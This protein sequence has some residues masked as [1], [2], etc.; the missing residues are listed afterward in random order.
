MT[1]LQFVS[2][3]LVAVSHRAGDYSLAAVPWHASRWTGVAADRGRALGRESRYIAIGILS[4]RFRIAVG[5][6]RGCLSVAVVRGLCR[7]LGVLSLGGA[8]GHAAGVRLGGRIGVLSLCGCFS[9]A[10]A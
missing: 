9:I 1:F 10:A 2:R 8:D 7:C 3:R 5:A 4:N 6:R